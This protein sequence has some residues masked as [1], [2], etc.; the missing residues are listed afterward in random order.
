MEP[1]EAEKEWR[2]T[3]TILPLDLVDRLRAARVEADAELTRRGQEVHDLR[4]DLHALRM[5]LAA[6]D[7]ELAQLRAEVQRLSAER[8]R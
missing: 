6:R 1:G 7:A 8:A 4:N 5:Q 3:Q 2:H